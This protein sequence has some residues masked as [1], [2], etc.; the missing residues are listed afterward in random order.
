MKAVYKR[1]PINACTLN[2]WKRKFKINFRRQNF[3]G[4]TY[5]SNIS[6]RAQTSSIQSAISLQFRI[7]SS[8]F[9]FF[10]AL[11]SHMFLDLIWKLVASKVARAHAHTHTHIY[12]IYIFFGLAFSADGRSKFSNYI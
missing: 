1:K 5:Q 2:K 8:W 12:T 10:L 11:S 7:P 4:D 3:A 9:T 6:N